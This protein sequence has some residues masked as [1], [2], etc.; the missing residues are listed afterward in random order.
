M[1]HYMKIFND[2]A[3][4]DI[5]NLYLLRGSE[6]FVM[7]RM[8]E[9]ITAMVVPDD[10]KT[11]NHTVAYGS[12]I[13]KIEEFIATAAAFPFLSDRRVLVLKE[14]EKLRGSWA[15]LIGYCENPAPA[16]I[17]IFLYNPF[18]EARGTA[19]DSKEYKQ[20]A[21]AVGRRGK[22]VEFERL[23]D[24][25]LLKWV[26]QEAKR[27][28]V[29]ID[30]DAA[31]ALVRSVGENLFDLKNEIDKLSLLYE[32]T[33]V[34]TG[35]LAAVIGG[36]RLNAVRD[37][38]ESI[39]P[40]RE[41]RALAVLHRIVRSGA[42]KPSAIIYQLTRHFLDCLKAKA[43]VSPGG[44]RQERSRRAAQAFTEREI[45][46]W[47]ENLRRAELLLKTSAFP[48]EALLVGALV[49]SFKGAYVDYPLMAA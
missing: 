1:T 21:A 7:E 2:V 44:Y 42:E 28:R 3:R 20:L 4:R 16:S 43:G 8:A 14:L 24:A 22:V 6:S 31:E 36:F 27:S 9:K 39:A 41:G 23:T 48:E 49:H 26:V 35:D 34:E 15:R 38:I 5:V 33:R 11:F 10:L 13:K 29:E 25:D 18:D 17:V 46:V 30:A 47:L 12:E 19:R 45:M 40:G 37:L 32:N